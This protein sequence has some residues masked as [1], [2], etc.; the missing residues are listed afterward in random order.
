MSVNTVQKPNC[1]RGWRVALAVALTCGGGLGCDDGKG[2]THPTDGG[3]VDVASA[4]GGRGGTGGR[5]TTGPDGGGTVD[6]IAGGSGGSGE[7]PARLVDE[8][9]NRPAAL[10]R[11]AQAGRERGEPRRLQVGAAAWVLRQAPAALRRGVGVSP[12]QA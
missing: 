5:G 3:P 10:A 2:V 6:A 8:R 7:P 1:L 12:E 4:T 9:V 11:E